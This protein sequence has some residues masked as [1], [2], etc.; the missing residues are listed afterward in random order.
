MKTISIL[1]LMGGVAKTFTA[2]NMAYELYRRGYKVLLIDNDKQGNLSK[3][4]SRYDAENVAPVTRLLAGDW[5][6]ADELIQHTEY[7]GIDIVTANMSLFGAT[8]NLTKEDSEN[9]IER[10]KALVYAK[11]QYYGDCTIYGK[12]DYCIID[13]SPSV[14]LLLTNALSAANEVIIPMQAQP[15]S[16]VGMSQLTNSISSVQRKINP[17]LHIRGVLLTMTQHTK[18]SEH[19]A[20]DVRAKYGRTL[21]VFTTEIPYNV[22]VQESQAFAAPTILYEPK[23]SSARAYVDFTQEVLGHGRE[24]QV[25]ERDE[26]ARDR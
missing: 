18:V 9:Q 17:G 13:C 6:S 14:G 26:D 24:E 11:V 16:V 22:K 4:Y 2:A 23:S 5:E 19:Y 3:A 25:Y 15:F 1:N 8:W 7:E 20:H 10:Y 12:Y 21:R